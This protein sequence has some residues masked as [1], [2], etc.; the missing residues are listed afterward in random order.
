MIDAALARIRGPKSDDK[1]DYRIK[2]RV[3]KY[4]LRND[5]ECLAE[6]VADYVAN[7]G[8]ANPLSKAVWSVLKNELQ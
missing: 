7:R 1:K 8:K 5:S 2:R 6:C 3:S 4:A